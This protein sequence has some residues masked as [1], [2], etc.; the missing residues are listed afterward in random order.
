[1]ILIKGV[2]ERVVLFQVKWVAGGSVS[3]YFYEAFTS[4]WMA[5][6]GG[7][8]VALRRKYPDYKLWIVGH[9]LGGAMASLAAS[10]IE[11]MKIAD[12]NRIKLVTFGQ[13]RTGDRAFAKA[14]GEQIP[15]SFRVT[16]A[17]DVVPQFPPKG[18]RNYY[19]HRSEVFY[20][21]NMTTPD[22]VECEE[23]E[24]G[25]CGNGLKRLSF[26]DHHRYFNVFISRWGA[27]GCVGDA[28]NPPRH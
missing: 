19:H 23:E 12:G 6:M 20:N 11:K 7:D 5:G 18:F 21:N 24:D 4:V 26:D 16:H 15:Y 9:S 25:M 22:Y 14:V 27:V 17:H 10:Y 8:V 1:M 2:G 3:N 28:V 13:P